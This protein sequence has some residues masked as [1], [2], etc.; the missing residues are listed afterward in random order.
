[1][2]DYQILLKAMKCL[3]GQSKTMKGHKRHSKNIQGIEDHARPGNAAKGKGRYKCHDR[4]SNT[5]KG[6]LR[7]SN[8]MKGHQKY[9][10]S[11]K[12]TK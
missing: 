12:S 11:S 4:L 6:P 1:M 8:A 5:I 3:I 10:R 9:Q 7:P 2:I